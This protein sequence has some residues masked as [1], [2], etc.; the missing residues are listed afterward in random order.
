MYSAAPSRGSKRARQDTSGRSRGGGA[1][2][3]TSSGADSNSGSIIV[4]VVENRS[5]ETCV[6][7]LN[8]AHAS[9]LEVTTLSDT[10]S[11]AQTMAH[12]QSLQPNEVLLHD[13][14]RS[15]VLSLKIV[16]AFHRGEDGRVLFVSRQYFDQ[17]RGAELLRRVST[18]TLGADVLAS[19]IVLAAANCL[20]RYVENVSGRGY[21]P[22]SL[23]V[24]LASGNEGRMTIDRS[25]ALELEL[26][27][28]AR[29][30]DQRRS[31]FGVINRTKVS[32]SSSQAAI[33]I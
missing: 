18:K 11:Y 10:Q 29:A 25:T 2:T 3:A 15:R 6:A 28:N 24:V 20:L 26:I 13:G 16:E 8:T 30:F 32:S 21:A 7:V 19:Y 27:V 17:D 4:A 31:L 5:R 14:S 12:L 23:R 9:L 1:A 22:S 33:S